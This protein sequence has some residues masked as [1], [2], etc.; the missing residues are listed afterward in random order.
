LQTI[1]VCR[2]GAPSVPQHFSNMSL[3]HPSCRRVTLLTLY[4]LALGLAVAVWG[5]GYKMEQ[6]PLYDRTFRV[7]VPAKLLTEKERPLRMGGIQ[8]GLVPA[9]QRPPL[10]RMP[11]W[12]AG[13][14]YSALQAMPPGTVVPAA[15]Y[16]KIVVPEF[17]YFFFRP[18]P[19]RFNP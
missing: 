16:C 10:L 8:T 2:D 17:T 5:A 14:R 19:S 12:I 4:G 18:P 7:M 11:A 15:R 9:D 3:L 1:A 13:I 6:Y